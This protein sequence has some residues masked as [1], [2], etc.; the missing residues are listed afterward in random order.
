M[1]TAPIE[2]VTAEVH[3]DAAEVAGSI[4]APLDGVGTKRVERSLWDEGTQAKRARRIAD[5]KLEKR[6]RRC[7]EDSTLR[8]PRIW[9]ENFRR[10]V[11]SIGGG[12]VQRA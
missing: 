2:V 3:D 12:R 9:R 7:E 10:R 8:D 6:Q 5:I 11:E 4:Q 1:G